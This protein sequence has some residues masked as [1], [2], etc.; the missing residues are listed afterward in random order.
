MQKDKGGHV[1]IG[2]L[3][4]NLEAINFV[5]LTYKL[6]PTVGLRIKTN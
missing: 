6:D 1:E 5:S 3:S 4:S 2:E